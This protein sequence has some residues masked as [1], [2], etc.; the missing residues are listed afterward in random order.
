MLFISP[1]GEADETQKVPG[2]DEN[3]IAA[4]QDVG[5]AQKA[6]IQ[7]TSKSAPSK[8]QANFD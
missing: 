5:L 1:L 7:V 8:F 4:L 2:Q 3:I 6:D